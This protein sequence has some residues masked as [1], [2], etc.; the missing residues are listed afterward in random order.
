MAK[1]VKDL[2]LSLWQLGLLLRYSFDRWPSALLQLGHRLQLGLRF[3]PSP[4]N[5]HMPWV[6]PKKKK[7]ICTSRV[8]HKYLEALD[9]F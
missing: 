8:L 3:D 7:K 1:Q 2:T 4:G 6:W 9:K 5:F